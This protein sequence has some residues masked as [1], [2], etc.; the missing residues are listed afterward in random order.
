MFAWLLLAVAEMQ[1]QFA[2]AVNMV[3]FLLLMRMF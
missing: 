2:V 1:G 3:L